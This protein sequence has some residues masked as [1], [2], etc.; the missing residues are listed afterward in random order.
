VKPQ[1][2]IISPNDFSIKIMRLFILLWVIWKYPF[3]KGHVGF[4]FLFSISIIKKLPC[5][6]CQNFVHNFFTTSYTK[7]WNQKTKWKHVIT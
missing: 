5:F 7:L 2:Y 6:H 3:K 1:V 4:H